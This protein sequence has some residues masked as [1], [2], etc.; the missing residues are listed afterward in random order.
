MSQSKSEAQLGTLVL[1]FKS[2]SKLLE[3]LSR[4][5][6]T[7]MEYRDCCSRYEKISRAGGRR[8]LS[9]LAKLVPELHDNALRDRIVVSRLRELVDDWMESGK[10]SDGELPSGRDLFRTTIALATITECAER[11]PLRLMLF[12]ETKQIV[13]V[14]G[15]NEVRPRDWWFGFEHPFDTAACI[16]TGLM[17]ADWNNLL[18]KCRYSHCNRY[19]LADSMIT[20]R[21]KHGTFCRPEHQRR[22]SAIECT[23]ER[24]KKADAE[25]IKV[26]AAQL[27][28]SRI[29][30][31]SWQDD[32]ARKRSLAGHLN[33]QIGRSKR[34]MRNAVKVNW[35]SLH[36]GEIEQARRAACRREA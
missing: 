20:R 31:P 26:A 10:N 27:E 30:S 36:A 11:H 28:K 33:Q 1:S 23:A 17:I 14:V 32:V 4:Q 16:F 19:F 34:Q 7:E 24:R 13:V 3:T 22:T 35:V 18:C 6:A 25:L 21:R 15:T 12:P 9:E 2:R 5:P 8:S 29:T